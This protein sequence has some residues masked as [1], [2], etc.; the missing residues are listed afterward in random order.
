[1]QVASL[2]RIHFLKCIKMKTRKKI[3]VKV[4]SNVVLGNVN[5]SSVSWEDITLTLS[6]ILFE[7]ISILGMVLCHNH[8]GTS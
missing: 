2:R 7:I 3:Y 5:V 1:M 6:D 4:N 8:L